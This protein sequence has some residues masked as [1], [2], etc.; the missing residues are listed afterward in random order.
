MAAVYKGRLELDRVVSMKKDTG[1]P[2][3]YVPVKKD[4][5]L[6]IPERSMAIGSLTT[7]DGYKKS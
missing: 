6:P 1:K 4:T 7:R 2:M 3:T 5:K